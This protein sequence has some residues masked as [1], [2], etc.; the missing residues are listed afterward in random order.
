MQ[1]AVRPHKF[2]HQSYSTLLK[3]SSWCCHCFRVPDES[4]ALTLWH[5]EMV[6]V[7]TASA[8][9]P[10][11]LVLGFKWWFGK[12]T[13]RLVKSLL[14]LFTICNKDTT[15]TPS[16]ILY[17]RKQLARVMLF[18]FSCCWRNDKMPSIGSRAVKQIGTL[19][20]VVLIWLYS[21]KYEHLSKEKEGPDTYR[22]EDRG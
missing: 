12:D 8:I 9:S 21:W 6:K 15:P 4:L 7:W 2:V 16:P 18:F 13:R 14:Y 20:V 5:K 17:F 11:I 3:I 10:V 22:K 1:S 19:C